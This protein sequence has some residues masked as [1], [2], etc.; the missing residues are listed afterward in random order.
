MAVD[1]PKLSVV[2]ASHNARISIEECLTSL[3][4]Q[5][6][7]SAEI[8]VVDNSTDGTTDI[9]R[10]QFPHIQLIPRSP[11]QLIPELWGAGIRQST[12]D[13]VAI[14]TAHFI[15]ETNW[16][17]QILEAHQDSSPAIG[18]A[19]E[20]NVSA[21]IVDWALYFCRYSK[22]MLPFRRGFVS[23]IAGDNASYKRLAIDQ[24]EHAWHDGFWEQAVHRELRKR[25]AQ[26]LIDPSIII[27]HK[28][29]FGF[30]E[31]MK[32]R[33]R[34]GRQFGGWR[35]RNLT[36]LTRMIHIGLSPM[37]PFVLLYRILRE[38]LVKHRHYKQLLLSLPILSLFLLAWTM[39]ELTG[40]VLS[41]ER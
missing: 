32:Q 9:L 35:L 33:Y 6:D 2:V 30:R 10:E 1:R 4:A 20:N 7:E 24:C 19:I 29:S 11:S 27:Y 41:A 40:Y 25:G 5:R 39:G 8:L 3:Q 17:A 37:I 34:H 31:F 16:V 21:G 15:P 18:G 38:V 36:G 23:E 12:G 26:L 14:T 22:Y 28:R 13:I